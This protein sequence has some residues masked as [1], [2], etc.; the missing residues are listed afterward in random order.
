LNNFLKQFFDWLFPLNCAGC[1]REGFALC[2]TCRASIQR[3]GDLFFYLA[4]GSAAFAGQLD[5]TAVLYL[6]EKEGPLARMLHLYKYGLMPDY[7]WEIAA[8]WQ[9]GIPPALK[10]NIAERADLCSWIPLHWRK[11]RWRGFNQS[12]LLARSLPLELPR[13]QLLIRT[14]DTIA[15]MSLKRADRLHNMRGAFSTLPS[16]QRQGDSRPLYGKTILLVDD[17]ITTGAT[18]AEAAAALKSA[19]AAEVLALALAGQREELTAES[20]HENWH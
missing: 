13:R 12:E 16:L 6:Y 11:E 18:L 15:Q 3:S 5:G 14:R 8:L 2:H 10:Q 19:G 20:E 17:V 9:S 7:G 1:N 4:G